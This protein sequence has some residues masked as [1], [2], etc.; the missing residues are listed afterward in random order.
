MLFNNVKI[1]YPSCE[2][3]PSTVLLI[4][5]LSTFFYQ[6]TLDTQSWNYSKLLIR[7]H[8]TTHQQM[9]RVDKVSTYE[10][11]ASCKYGINIRHLVQRL[12]GVRVG[13]VLLF[14]VCVNLTE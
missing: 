6:D 1:L 13:K 8:P 14:S 3:C 4:L 7:G 11:C 5:L 9:C 2:I 10:S 12:L